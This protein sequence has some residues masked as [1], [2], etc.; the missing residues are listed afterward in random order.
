MSLRPISM[1]D[2]MVIALLDGQKTETRRVKKDDKPPYAPGDL[3]WV[4]EMLQRDT[5]DGIARYTRHNEP[6]IP[7]LCWRWKRDVLPSRFMPKAATRIW[8]KALEVRPEKLL[9]IHRPGLKAEGI[10]TAEPYGG[11]PEF[12]DLWNHLH[13]K[14]GERWAENPW[15]WVIRFERT[16]AGQ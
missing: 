7:F 14:P 5:I 15:V 10:D 8:L 9:E 2:V 16:E 13:A 6:V 3:L 11:W 12:A 4:K 1:C